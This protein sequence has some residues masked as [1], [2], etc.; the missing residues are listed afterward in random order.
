MPP[1]LILR[2]G[3]A[4]IVN[5]LMQRGYRYHLTRPAGRNFDPRFRPEL[6]SRQMLRLGVFGGKYMTDCGDE[7]P[8]S[9]FQGARLSPE[10]RDP[11]LNYFGVNASQSLWL[12]PVV[13]PLLSRP[14]DRG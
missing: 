1:S 7:F 3:K 4:V 11:E 6:T 10:F 13:L 5:D 2:R 9:W 8:A 12:V 14:P